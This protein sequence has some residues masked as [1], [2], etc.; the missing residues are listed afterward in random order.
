MREREKERERERER[1]REGGE[2]PIAKSSSIREAINSAHSLRE[3]YV[4]MA[5]VSRELASER[6]SSKPGP[7]EYRGSRGYRL[8]ITP[9]GV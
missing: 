4:A 7:I 9:R 1:E 2:G 5:P 3:S 6:K 8:S